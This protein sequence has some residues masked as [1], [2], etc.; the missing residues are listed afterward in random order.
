MKH[1]LSQLFLFLVLTAPVQSKNVNNDKQKEVTKAKGD[2]IITST[3]VDGLKFRSIG[4]AW[5]SG[6]ISDLA[7]NP[8]NTKEYYVGVASGNVWKT[9][10]SGITGYAGLK[11]TL[12]R[13]LL[14]HPCRI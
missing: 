6:R 7:V 12:R 4:P 14:N 13:G 1:F 11:I 5:C 8:K 9:T 10:N 2:T 3:L